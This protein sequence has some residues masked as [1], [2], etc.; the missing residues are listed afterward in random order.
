MSAC[1]KGCMCGEM[2]QHQLGIQIATMANFRQDSDH[3]FKGAPP[4][5]LPLQPLPPYL[6]IQ[7]RIKKK[8]RIKDALLQ[9]PSDDTS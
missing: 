2:K 9:A 7:E 3:D 5:T 1:E 4:S 6:S 8:K